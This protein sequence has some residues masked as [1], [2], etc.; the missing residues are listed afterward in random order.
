MVVLGG[1]AET[2]EEARALCEKVVEQGQALQRFG[3]MIEAQGGDRR[4]ID[5]LALLPAALRR[6]DVPAPEGG[7]VS[8]LLARPIGHAS[9]L[10]GAGRARVDSTIDPAVGVVLHKK[11]GDAVE[12]GERLCTLHVSDEHHLE[13]AVHLI[14]AAFRLGDHPE[15]LPALIRARPSG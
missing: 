5:D 6:I 14:K 10:L 3:R 11:Q 8:R 7:F 4:V 15:P 9:M 12:P 13:E 1:Q 2:V